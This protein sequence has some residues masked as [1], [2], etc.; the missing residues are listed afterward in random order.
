[1]QY[2]GEANSQ[3]IV[4]EVLSSLGD[5]TTDDYSLN[6]M[7]RRANLAMSMIWHAIFRSYGGWQYDDTNQTNLPSSADA[8]TA[9]QTTYSLPT[10]ALTVKGVSVKSSDNWT[11]LKPLNA[12]QIKDSQALD[13]FEKTAGTPNSYRL[14]GR[15]VIIY[16]ASDTTVTGGFKVYFDRAGVAFTPSDT[17][18]E[19]GFA[20]EY[21]GAVPVF[22]ALKIGRAHV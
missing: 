8:L 14:V 1:M 21:H 19:P 7:T 5:I 11:D 4:S 10:E 22:M 12:E 9:N 13:E 17:T 3:D 20:S 16:P 6:A 15:S 18:A 2:N